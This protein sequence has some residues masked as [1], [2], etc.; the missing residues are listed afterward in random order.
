MRLF[1]SIALTDA[2]REHLVKSREDIKQTCFTREQLQRMRWINETEYHVTQYFIGEVSSERVDA[3][4]SVVQRVAASTNPFTLTSDRFEF[5]PRNNPR[6]LW[7]RFRSSEGY[8]DLQ[9]RL[10]NALAEAG[11]SQN[12]VH[13]DPISHVTLIRLK[14]VKPIDAELP[15]MTE[16]K[17][18]VKQIDLMQSLMKPNGA[19][20]RVLERFDLTK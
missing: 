11:V 13:D 7:L 2:L 14:Q 16:Q 4:K 20:Y 9:T 15:L 6:L 19:E 1:L 8:A 5:K 12:E 18:E 3:L 17:I 10:H